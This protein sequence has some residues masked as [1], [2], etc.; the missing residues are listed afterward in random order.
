MLNHHPL[1]RELG[2][3]S[4]SYEMILPQGMKFSFVALD[5][6]GEPV[7]ASETLGMWLPSILWDWPGNDCSRRLHEDQLTPTFA[8][9]ATQV[10]FESGAASSVITVLRSAS[11]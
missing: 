4:A 9:G 10:P 11:E 1:H 8:F 3:G 5:E 2:G 6:S 7:A